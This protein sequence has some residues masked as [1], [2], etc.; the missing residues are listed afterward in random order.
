[1]TSLIHS[2][3]TIFPLNYLSVAFFHLS[4]LSR[5]HSFS[6]INVTLITVFLFSFTSSSDSFPPFLYLSKYQWRCPQLYHLTFLVQTYQIPLWTCSASTQLSTAPLS[7]S[8]R[9]SSGEKLRRPEGMA[10]HSASD[11]IVLSSYRS[12]GRLQ[13]CSLLFF[14]FF[15]VFLGIQMWVSGQAGHHHLK[16]RPQ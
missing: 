10:L 6:F 15:L 13:G 5:C 14:S 8:A 9:Q 7:S 12:L 3:L 1:M 2:L 11:R 4:S 16:S